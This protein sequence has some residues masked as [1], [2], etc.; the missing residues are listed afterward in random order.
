M[1]YSFSW[2][3][4]KHRRQ[5]CS[6]YSATASSDKKQ[7]EKHENAVPIG[8]RALLWKNCVWRW[9]MLLY[10]WSPYNG[11]WQHLQRRKILLGQKQGKVLV[12]HVGGAFNYK[13]VIQCE[14]ILLK[15]Q[16]VNKTLYVEIKTIEFCCMIPL[17]ISH[18]FT[19]LR[20]I[21]LHFSIHPICLISIC[22]R[23]YKWNWRDNIL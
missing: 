4:H 1:A 22:F 5:P 23:G 10:L 6:R 11:R 20:I 7:W 16:T 9:D 15:G 19:L 8:S 2:R 18:F 14:F 12:V 21:Q 17:D 3:M 13:C